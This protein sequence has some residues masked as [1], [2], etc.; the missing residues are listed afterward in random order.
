MNHNLS[1]NASSYPINDHLDLTNFE[2]TLSI[3]PIS[4]NDSEVKLNIK[5]IDAPFINA[6]RRT[7]LDDVP[8]IAIDK[9]LIFQNTSVIN[10]EVLV[11]RLG[12]IPI[13]ANPDLFMSKREDTGF[14]DSNCVKFKLKKKCDEENN[15]EK[16]YGRN[17]MNNKLS[18]Y[19]S[20]MILDSEFH[21]N[22]EI[23]KNMKYYF[24][25]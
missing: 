20:D 12:L 24:Y 23:H 2:K 25:Y 22:S 17:G 14:N 21:Q 11:H 8:S 19:A 7:M 18:V 1:G 5:G 13:M 3:E 15:D 4:I 10:D 6:L 9:V 16:I